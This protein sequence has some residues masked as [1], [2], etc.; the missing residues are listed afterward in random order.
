MEKF[1]HFLFN[2]MFQ[3]KTDQKPWETVLAKCLTKATPR[4]QYLSVSTLL[5]D[6]SVKYINESTN[7]PEDC[8]SRVG[9]LDDKI[10]LPVIHVHQLPTAL[11]QQQAGS[12]YSVKLLHKVIVCA[13]L[14][15]LCKLDGQARSKEC[16]L[17]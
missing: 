2:K 5:Y 6:F 8:F 4:L 3:L 14:S 7:K 10:K 17:R 12:N 9:P 15:I 16:H 11:K 1:I 13:Q